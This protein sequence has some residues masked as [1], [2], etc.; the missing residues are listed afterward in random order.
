MRAKLPKDLLDIYPP[1][2]GDVDVRIAKGLMQ[3]RAL[4]FV[5]PVARIQRQQLD[6]SAFGQVGRLVEH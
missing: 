6:F 5:E 1:A 2:F 4:G 3:G